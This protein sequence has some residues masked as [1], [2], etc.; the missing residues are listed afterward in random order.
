MRTL[1]REKLTQLD[2]SEQSEKD[3]R[4]HHAL[5]WLERDVWPR[6]AGVNWLSREDEDKLLG[7]DEMTS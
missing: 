1:A 5:Q 7:Y 3:A 2:S 6:A 4:L